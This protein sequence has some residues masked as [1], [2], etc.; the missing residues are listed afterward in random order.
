MTILLYNSVNL[1]C[2]VFFCSQPSVPE[3]SDGELN[4]LDILNHDCIM[5]IFSHLHIRYL[6]RSERV[7]KKWKSL[8]EDKLQSE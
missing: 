5:K 2:F 4:M 7:S 6:I 8:V 1:I 3:E